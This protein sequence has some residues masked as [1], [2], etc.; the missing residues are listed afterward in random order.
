[1]AFA[2][3]ASPKTIAN[4][5]KNPQVAVI[6]FD[7]ATWAGCRLTGTAEIIESGDL[8][9]VF[10]SQFAPLKMKVHSVVKITVEEVAMMPPMKAGSRG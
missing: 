2:E 1:M 9:D 4:L 3:I 5:R 10:R 7:P 8:V 6:V